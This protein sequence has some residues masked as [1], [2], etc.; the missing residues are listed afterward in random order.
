MF[1]RTILALPVAA[2]AFAAVA[3]AQTSATL[4][5]R[6]GDRITGQ[7][8]D[9]GGVG[10]TV[11]IDGAERNITATDVAVIDFSGG[12]MTD[13]DWE[14]V[15]GDNQVIWLKSGETVSGQLFDISG[16]SPLKITFKTA[17]GD[18]EFSSSEIGRI[19]F[20]RPSNPIATSGASLQAPVGSGISINPKQPA[21][22]SLLRVD[23]VEAHAGH[24]CGDGR[25]EGI[26]ARHVRPAAAPGPGM[27]GS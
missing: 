23:R 26:R 8:V 2:L 11:R 15:S 24:P 20:A 16:T 10:F 14:K 12:S 4:T 22:S 1:K 13:A 21:A 6:N 19:V 27:E 9:L 5:L 25:N 3:Q 18:R 7:L 17:S